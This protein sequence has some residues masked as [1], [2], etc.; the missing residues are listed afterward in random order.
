MLSNGVPDTRL[1]CLLGALEMRGNVDG[2]VDWHW[3]DGVEHAAIGADQ[4]AAM[5]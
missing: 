5:F 1:S 3:A 2:R 4:A